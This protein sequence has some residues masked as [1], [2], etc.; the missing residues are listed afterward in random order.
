MNTINII[1]KE[2]PVVLLLLAPFV[3]SLILSDKVPETVPTHFNLQGEAD[4]Y[5]PKWTILYMLP[6]IGIILYVALLLL[7]RIDPKKRIEEAQ[8]PIT[9]IRLITSLFMVGLYAMM[10]LVVTGSDV[11]INS[12]VFIAVGILFVGLGNYINTVKPNYFIGIRTP[13]TL[14]N[15]KVW[16]K[17]H[18]LGSKIWM[19]GGV[20]IIISDLL[21][22]ESVNAI[23]FGVALGFMVVVPLLYSYF[24]FKKIDSTG[25]NA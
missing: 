20:L 21:L 1:K 12:Y 14:E 5:G 6:A 2:W 24:E 10:M 25:E 7:P 17:T 9:A 3:V 19:A 4:D 23:V 13:W 11:S 15:P 16:K 18:R 8:K 22:S